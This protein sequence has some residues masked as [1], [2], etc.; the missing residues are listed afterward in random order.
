MIR[1]VKSFELPLLRDFAPPE[2]NTDISQRFSLYFGQPYFYPIVAE[3]AGKIV[4]CANG[5][6]NGTT[7]WLGNIIVL[8]EYRGQGIGSA[9]ASHLVEY[10]HHQGC[11]SQVLVAT[12]LGE[13]VYARL[14]FKVSSSYTFLR[15]EK[16]IPSTLTPQIHRA[17]AENFEAMRKLD[18]EI[19]GERRTAFLE[20]FLARGWV[21]Q[22][23]NHEPISGFFLPSLENGPILARDAVTGLELLQFKLGSGCTS[24]VVPSSNHPTL[25]L[26]LGSGF[27][28][29][30]TAP[31]MTLGVELDWKPEGVFSRGGGFCG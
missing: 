31:R 3:L 12:K 30:N 9:L 23:G 18:L 7:S 17:Q 6:L 5:L 4:G 27:Q 22:A 14:G 13:P 16:T 28:I 2:W 24:V 21:S 19:T 25:D 8:P 26:L 11:I 15:S 1:P 10:L 20:R 29:E